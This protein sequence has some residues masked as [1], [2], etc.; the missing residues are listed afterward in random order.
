ML[1]HEKKQALA[2]MLIDLLGDVID[3][4]VEAAIQQRGLQQKQDRY[5]TREEAAKLKNVTPETISKWFKA[6]LL[7][8]YGTGRKLLFSEQQLLSSGLK[9]YSQHT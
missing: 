9:R 5:L 1:I 4:R 6:K 8:N 2:D 3:Q 7:T